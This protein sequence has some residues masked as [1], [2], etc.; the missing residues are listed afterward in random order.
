M[1]AE[2]VSQEINFPRPRSPRQSLRNSMQLPRSHR[3]LDWRNCG[4]L[5]RA[6]PNH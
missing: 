2:T 1:M 3:L 6:Q 5:R 4:P